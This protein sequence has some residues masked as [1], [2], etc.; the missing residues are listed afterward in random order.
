VKFET[1]GPQN[2]RCGK[3]CRVLATKTLSRGLVLSQST[4]HLVKNVV[5]VVFPFVHCSYLM[6]CGCGDILCFS[7]CIRLKADADGQLPCGW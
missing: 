2:S 5:T 7:H 3:C 4:F 1:S 6:A